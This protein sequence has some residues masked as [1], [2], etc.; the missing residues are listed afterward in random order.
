VADSSDATTWQGDSRQML[1]RV[2]DASVD[3]I[4]TDP[5]YNLGAYSTGNIDMS[6]RKS[7]NNDVAAWD[8][9]AFEPAEWLA[10][11][12]ENVLDRPD[13]V[14]EDGDGA[15]AKPDDQQPCRGHP[16]PR[17]VSPQP[18]DRQPDH[19]Q[20]DDEAGDPK[21]A[22]RHR[23]KCTAGQEPSRRRVAHPRNARR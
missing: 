17:P 5:P 20:G 3:L 8:Q 15:Q 1:A 19:E 9:L 6:W 21:K 2:P 14:R 16:A 13:E 23:R 12:A 7:F 22:D 11:E 18:A 10:G 4:C